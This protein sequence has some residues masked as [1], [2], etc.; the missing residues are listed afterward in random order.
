M[1]LALSNDKD[2]E[3]M[4]FSFRNVDGIEIWRSEEVSPGMTVSTRMMTNN[5]TGGIYFLEAFDG[6]GPY[7][8]E[9]LSEQQNDAGL[10]KDAGDRIAEAVKITA[11]RAIA[12]E[13]G[14]LD[15]EDWYSFSDREGNNI[16]FTTAADGEPLKLSIGNVARRKELYTAELVPGTTKTFEVPKNVQPPYFLKVYGGSSRYNFEIK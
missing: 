10:G 8:F 16:L 7:E 3:S 6:G 15:E 4:K 13:L 12:G 9:I 1:S 11:G 5:T 2:N 14:G